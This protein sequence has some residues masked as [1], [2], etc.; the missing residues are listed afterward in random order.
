MQH[1][2][3]TLK[4]DLT[5]TIL[6]WSGG[7]FLLLGLIFLLTF[8]RLECYIIDLMA[9]HRLN[10]Q[11]REFAKHLDQQDARSIREESDALI[12]ECM[13]T[14]ILMIDASGE[15][16]HVSLSDGENPK[17]RLSSSLRGSGV[18]T[19]ISRHS[20]LHLYKRA[21]PGHQAMLLLV[22]DDRPRSTRP[23]PGVRC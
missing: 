23:R 18:E 1:V 16:M 15:L 13:I 9:D 19:E 17:L 10:Y 7:F 2:H 6:L 11:T 14:A 3:H 4:R 21:I 20:N 12:Q 8:Q 22:L 5:R